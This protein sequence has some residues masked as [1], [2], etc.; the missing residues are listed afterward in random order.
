LVVAVASHGQVNVLTQ[1]ND[2]LRTGA[3]LNEQT[4]NTSNVH[5]SFGKLFCAPVD[6]YVYAQPLYMA[7]LS[8]PGNGTHNILFLATAYNS[9]Y[10]LDADDGALLWQ[11][12]LGPAVPS[13][14]VPQFPTTNIQNWVGIISTPVIDASTSTLYVVANTYESGTF[15]FKLHALDV[16]SGAEKFGGPVQISP[17]VSGSGYGDAPSGLIK[18]NAQYQ[19]QRV[20]L[21]L[22]NNMIYAAFTSHEDIDYYHGWLLAYS[23]SNLQASPYVFNTT[24]NSAKSGRGGIWMAGQGLVVDGTNNVYLMTANSKQVTGTASTPPVDYDEAFLKMNVSN[25]LS[26]PLDSFT[27]YNF[28]ALNQSDADLGSGGPVGI[29]STPYIV[30]GGK[31]GVL[32]VVDTRN[33][34]GF[35]SGA[36]LAHQSFMGDN[37]LSG[38]PIFWN[39]SS[40]PTLYVWGQ[41]DRLKGYPY[42]T[43]SGTF[44]VTSSN[45]GIPSSQSTVSS[46]PSDGLT[47]G[48]LS[49]SANGATAGT[50]IVWATIAT[51]NP[52]VD[53]SVKTARGTLYAFDATNLATELWDSRQNATRDD[54]GYFAKFVPPT[55]TNGKVYVA[56][57]TYQ[58]CAYGLNPPAPAWHDTDINSMSNAHAAAGDPKSYVLGSQILVYRGTD[59]HLHQ[60]WS[61]GNQAQW[62]YSDLTPLTGAPA[63]AGTPFGY[64]LGAEQAIVFRGNDGHIYQVNT[65]NGDA[66]WATAAHDLTTLTAAPV[67]AGDPVGYVVSGNQYIDYLGMDGHIHQLFTINGNAQW[68]QAA[69]LTLLANA[70]TSASDPFEYSFGT[71]TQIVVFRGSDNHIHQLATTDN[72][73]WAHLDISAAAGAAAAAGDPSA[74]V[75]GNQIVNYR[76]TDGHVHQ[77]WSSTTSGPWSTDDVS[78]IVGA[79]T[80]AGDPSSYLNGN[81]LIVY[82]GTD[83][84]VHQLS[85]YNNDT[86]WA[87]ADLTSL[88]GATNAGGN[89]LGYMF[90]N[91]EVAYR[92]T[93]GHI[94]VMYV[95]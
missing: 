64:V 88:A 47:G 54:F 53:P 3:N 48:A 82:L 2:N 6:G 49:L 32:Y 78:A 29:P 13:S 70:P 57:D 16:T 92:G 30:G 61:W 44:P 91:Q 39:N 10:A 84:H 71:E 50:A 68:A 22:A 77:I 34:G 43:S 55:V 81:Q 85:S 94:H 7:N 26:A 42:Q 24:A 21:T 83:S 38:A 5:S 4:L 1:H 52:P 23:A 14:K 89:P 73:T 20:A 79:G 33:M 72:S 8:I 87:Q 9:V 69:D 15:H 93:E 76:G 74:Y 90:I 51:S 31:Q 63:L 40:A 60:V 66:A 27:P 86:Q 67:A 58:I 12:S 19:N 59:S 36:D 62:L 18:F 11:L 95:Q 28:L 25:S 45:I 65:V 41:N 56:T 75:L 35:N 37:G 17:Q 80:A 46:Q